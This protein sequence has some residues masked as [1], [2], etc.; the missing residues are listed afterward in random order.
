MSASK[1]LGRHLFFSSG[2]AMAPPP[3]IR[4]HVD[5]ATSA[6]NDA[7]FASPVLAGSVI[8]VRLA[9]SKSLTDPAMAVGSGYTKLAG[10]HATGTAG[11]A[12]ASGTAA[13]FYKVAAGGEQVI[14]RDASGGLTW[15]CVY[16]LTGADASA[17]QVISASDQG[18]S[19]SSSIGSVTGAGLAFNLHIVTGAEAGVHTFSGVTAGGFTE[20]HD[21]PV[22]ITSGQPDI[23]TMWLGNATA[24]GGSV[25]SAVTFSGTQA[26]VN[27]AG[28]AILL[29]GKLF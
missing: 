20:V 9:R 13:M 7:T 26:I 16:E 17:I 14:S 25:L 24:T 19:G 18:T 4:Q 6:A 1:F 11:D 3:T 12:G 22:S 23:P 28:I 15:M 21:Q 27:T 5:S 29:P 2:G 8:L 10:V